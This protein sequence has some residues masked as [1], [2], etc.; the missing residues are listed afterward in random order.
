MCVRVGV[1]VWCV[2]VFCVCVCVCLCVCVS[3]CARAWCV[4][5]CVCVCVR[6]C[7]SMCVC[8]AVSLSV[9]VSLSL[10]LSVCMD[11]RPERYEEARGSPPPISEDSQQMGPET[12][13]APQS[14]VQ[15][16]SLIGQADALTP[17]LA[18]V[19]TDFKDPLKGTG[20]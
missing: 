7:L 16:V 9:S 13:G 6:L 18:S 12:N 4:C 10:S 2:C 3:A 11:Q 20:F 1:C 14:F 5:V 17:Y 8:V 19:K 15:E